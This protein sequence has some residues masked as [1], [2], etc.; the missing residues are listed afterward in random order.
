M[1]ITDVANG[2]DTAY[3]VAEQ[4][5]HKLIVVGHVANGGKAD[6]GVLRYG[7]NGR[8]D[9]SFDG[10]GI[11][12]LGFGSDYEFAQASA[13]SSRTDAS[14]WS[15]ASV[16]RDNDQF[17]VVRLKPNGAYDMNFSKDGRVVVD[18]GGGSDTARD[19]A[20]Q[21]DGRIVVVGEA[22]DRGHRRFGVATTPRVP[23]AR[24]R[25]R[26]VGAMAP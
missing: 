15:D 12:I 18:F 9:D 6:W 24:P 2:A 22:F 26:I 1:K 7:A 10:D 21:R 8:L 11:R 5:D 16:A 19:V 14:S 4:P 20:L 23:E 3:G 13:V 17:G 25:G